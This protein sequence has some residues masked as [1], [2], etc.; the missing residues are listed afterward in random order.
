MK[1]KSAEEA[2]MKRLQREQEE[3]DEALQRALGIYIV[4][5][6]HLSSLSVCKSEIE[7]KRK[8]EDERVR[9]TTSSEFARLI[10]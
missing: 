8:K 7:K 3:Q 5:L 9:D 2:E 1:V 6:I 4:W 10:V